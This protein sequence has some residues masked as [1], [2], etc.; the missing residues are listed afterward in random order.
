MSPVPSRSGSAAGLKTILII[1]DDVHFTATLTLG[2]EANG[3]RTLCAA[4]AAAGW[5]MARAHLP[6]VILC[7]IQ[8]PGKDG[9]ALLQEMRADPELA[10]RQFVLMTGKA[11]FGSPRAAM[12]LGADDLLLKPFGLEDLLRCVAARLQRAELSRRVDDRV[13]EQLRENLHSTLPQEFFTPL[14]GILGLTELLE[15]QL[16][17]LSKDEILQD[18]QDIRRS[19]RRLHR[20]LRN[21]LRMLDLDRPE[22]SRPTEVLDAEAVAAAFATGAKAAAE[23]HQRTTDMVTEL[24]VGGLKADP[25]DLT[26]LAEE[27][28]D[29][30]LSF[31]RRDTKVKVKAWTDAGR[32]HLSVADSGR[33]MTAS[34]LEEIGAFHQPDR[35]LLRQQG[36][37]LG[38]ALVR[39][40][41]RHL[42]G[43]FS[44]DSEAG[45]GTTSHLSLPLA[46]A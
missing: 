3:Y 17:M 38:L 14:A 18:L 43:E 40:L 13:L 45:K 1:D 36:L 10:D 25:L 2:L 29:N 15:K 8:M 24:A 6:D 12:D 5:R 16:D 37:G 11:A 35:T 44:L 27:L 7:D 33:G 32:L 22:T 20:T 19:A 28:V 42:G 39:K 26:I 9:R 21:Y 46:A 41:A 31:S 4:D 30:G 23:R 34:Q